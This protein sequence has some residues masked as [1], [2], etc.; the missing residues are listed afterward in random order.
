MKKHKIFKN[1]LLFR[2]VIFL[3]VSL[4][5][6]TTVYAGSNLIVNVT[7]SILRTIPNGFYMIESGNSSNRVLYIN[8]WNINNLANL[9]T[10]QKNGTTNQIFYI[11][12]VGDGYYKIM[13]I[14]SEKYLDVDKASSVPGTNVQQYQWNGCSAQLWRFISAGNGYYY[15][16][17]KVGTYLD[18]QDG[19]TRNGNN[20]RTFYFNGSNAE[21]WKLLSTSRPS[22]TMS[23]YN[24]TKPYSITKGSGFTVKGTVSSNY[25]LTKVVAGIYTTR[26]VCISQKTV[27]PGSLSFNLNSIDRYL[28]FSYCQEGIYMYKIQA[29]DTRGSKTLLNTSF[30]VK[31]KSQSWYSESLIGGLTV[32]GSKLRYLCG[33][34]S[35][36]TDRKA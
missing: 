28:H 26:G 27:Y 35:I 7:G 10:Y 18:N 25:P 31:A 16:Q 5:I 19:S 33:N 6:N 15:I 13:A 22:S 1:H 17:S 24:Y 12:Y 11:S 8:N 23:L 21:K 3:V 4:M 29:W 34:R 32:S 30:L 9:E 2:C 20:V 14:H 36:P